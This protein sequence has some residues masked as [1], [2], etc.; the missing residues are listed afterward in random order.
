[1]PE[2]LRLPRAL[3]EELLRL[4]RDSPEEEVCGL[5]AGR[6]GEARRLFPIRN[7]AADRRRFFEL[8]PKGQ[9]DALR[10]MREAG[11]TLLA[12]YHSHPHGPGEPSRIDIEHHAYPDALCLVI[13]PGARGLRAFRMHADGAVEAPIVG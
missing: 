4:A 11:E 13:A 12:I 10:A 7:V 9:I 5:V 2:A 6:D 1:M 8:D 3:A